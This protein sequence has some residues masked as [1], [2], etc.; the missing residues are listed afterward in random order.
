MSFD[1][2]PFKTNPNFRFQ[3]AITT[4]SDCLSATH[5]F[6]CYQDKN[7]DTIL[8]SPYFDLPKAA[9][10]DHH[11]S[12]INLKNN[13]VVQTL[14]AHKD[15]VTTVRHFQD[16]ETKNDY[17]ISADK[18]YK[19]IVWNL[20]NDN[21]K[22]LET[23][24]KYEGFIYG[25]LLL[26]INKKIYAVVSSIGSNSITRVIEVG[27][28]DNV[29]EIK[30]SKELIVYYLAHWVN[31]NAADNESKHVIIQCA[32]NKI[33]FSEFPKNN[34]YH[35]IET[36]DK[37]PYIQAG[38]VFKNKG[39][40]MF[41][42]SITYGKVLF[43]DL[44][45]KTTVKEVL[46]DD[47]H[48]Y[49]FVRWNDHYLLLNDCLQRRIIVFDTLDGFKVKS[50]VLCPEMGFERF[51]KKI[52]HPKYGECI[53]SVGIDWTIKLFVNRSILKSVEEKK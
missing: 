43:V 4:K 24:V 32:K 6:D 38:I 28:K 35:K 26:F 30:D 18:K 48:L 42:A 1:E 47:V 45:S 12:L 14:E 34:T 13:E 22:V 50:K 11:I 40:D 25:C 2:I 37:F 27:N 19:I 5:Q 46:M 33:L 29:K 17:L 23:E 7:G 41:A 52:I 44:A 31:E 39:K 8:I 15:R 53:L 16:P 21:E 51:I 36:D 9:E 49:S 20:S 10:R 3:E